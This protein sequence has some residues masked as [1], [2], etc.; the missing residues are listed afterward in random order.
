[1]RKVPTFYGKK[2]NELNENERTLLHIDNM[3]VLSFRMR[4]QGETMDIGVLKLGTEEAIETLS[5]L[6]YKQS[7]IVN[8]MDTNTRCTKE[9]AIMLENTR[10]SFQ[11]FMRDYMRLGNVISEFID[12][13][14][15][16]NGNMMNNICL[17]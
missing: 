3:L 11:M 8:G 12:E 17:N 15:I 5:N 6:R 16:G 7:L 2:L 4:E 9:V 1:M 13:K 10:Y 14:M